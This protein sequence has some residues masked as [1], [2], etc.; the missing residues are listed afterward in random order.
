MSDEIKLNLPL[1]EDSV[2][3][4]HC[5][6]L[7]YLTGLLFTARDA[8]HRRLAEGIIPE[9]DLRGTVLYHCGPVTVLTESG[10]RVTAA[11]PTTSSREE[12]YMAGLIESLGLRGIIG[13]G[14][15][16]SATLKACEK[17]GCV[18][19]HA[20]G[21]AAQLLAD[22]VTRVVDVFWLDELGPPEAVWQLKVKNFPVVVTMDANGNSLHAEVA[23]RS[24][25]VLNS[26]L[27][28]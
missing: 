20:V 14:G 22:C 15:M 1:S 21:G 5:G 7:V 12:P 25:K 18:Y 17:F 8:V 4:L 11:G 24:E 10:W 23:E 9:C 6:D 2:R 13:K 27:C 19:F 16:G 28:K 26:F 3:D